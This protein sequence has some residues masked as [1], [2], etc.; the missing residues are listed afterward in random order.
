MMVESC[1]SVPEGKAAT[2]SCPRSGHSGRS[3]DWLTVAALT[4]GVVPPPQQFWLCR[5]PQCEVVYFGE[6]GTMVTT[7]QMSVVPGFKQSSA[8]G[9]VCYCFLHRRGDI[10]GELR[11]TG[12]TTVPDRIAAEVKAGNCACEVRNP[13]GRCCLGD[14]QRAIEAIC[15]ERI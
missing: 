2:A 8:E 12:D 13:T 5:D 7:T 14:V 6:R 10:E 4:S 11:E 3:V 15:Q 1:C 9:L